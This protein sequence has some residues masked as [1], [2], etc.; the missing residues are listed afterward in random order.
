MH[1][2]VCLSCTI[3]CQYADC[4]E[5]TLT[6]ARRHVKNR[7]TFLCF[8]LISEH[9]TEFIDF[10][11]GELF[12]H[13]LFHPSGPT[14]PVRFVTIGILGIETMIFKILLHQPY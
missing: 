4:A 2:A 3:N 1:S 11:K 6:H 10:D 12:P 5:G 13:K 8:N 7:I 14:F 9:K